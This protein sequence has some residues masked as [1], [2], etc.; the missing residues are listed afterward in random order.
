MDHSRTDDYNTNYVSINAIDVVNQTA[1]TISSSYVEQITF[2]F[3]TGPSTPSP[4][5]WLYV[6]NR[7]GSTNVFT[8]NVIYQ[9]PY[10]LI[11]VGV[12]GFQTITLPS[13]A[14]PI[15]QFQ[16]VGVGFEATGGSCYHVP[17][18]DEFYVGTNAFSR[19]SY[20]AYSS[21]VNSGFA[22]S[23]VVRITGS[24]SG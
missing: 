13:N 14:L 3:T 19:L 23:F 18:R 22:F 1:G 21:S 10:S 20:M 11:R 5:I 16:Y 24:L 12:A 7:T 4:G 17:N 2:V 9:L 6:M 8:P 15:R